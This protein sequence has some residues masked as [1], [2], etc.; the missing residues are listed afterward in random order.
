M[1]LLSG[2][3]MEMYNMVLLCQITCFENALRGGDS[4]QEVGGGGGGGLMF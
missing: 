4:Y 2:K 1:L 3:Y